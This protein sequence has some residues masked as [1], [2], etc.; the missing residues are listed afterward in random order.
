[1][2]PS[3][4]L[5]AG[6]ALAAM[7]TVASAQT[8]NGLDTVQVPTVGK[9]TLTM[10]TG[11]IVRGTS[12]TGEKRTV[13]QLKFSNTDTSGFYGTGA[14]LS[15]NGNSIEWLDWGILQ[16]RSSDIVTGFTFG[17]GTT[18]TD[19]ILGGPGATATLRFYDGIL[20]FC[21][22]SGNAA[23]CTFSFTGL[24][25]APGG[26]LGAG[27]L[28]TVDLTDGFEWCQ[29]SG[30]FGYGFTTLDDPNL[31]GARSTG[32]L[33]CYAGTVSGGADGNGQ[34]D[35]FDEWDGDPTSNNC[36]GTFFF[37]GP[38]INFS[39]W[40]LTMDCVDADNSTQA[41]G[42]F[43]NGGTNPATYTYVSGPEIGGLYVATDGQTTGLGCFIVGYLSPLSFNTQYGTILVNIA[44]PG[45]EVLAPNNGPYFYSG[46][47][48]SISINVPKNTDLCGVAVFTQTV[49]FGGGVKLH[50]A[51]DL[52]VGY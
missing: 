52:I 1:M 10:S 19:A 30:P 22:D 17:Y 34:V 6:L 38:P 18:A 41:S 40:Y 13:S 14:V 21:A 5:L 51:N 7:G 20:G 49:E 12:D 23:T 45:G 35:A 11:E 31:S 8:S 27:W 44:D 47:V 42:T 15:V 9:A 28:V 46:G 50:N 36:L 3:K 32:P 16:P 24:P 43:R 26:G 29:P 4:T 25:G 33:L 48:A 2:V 39:S 37:G